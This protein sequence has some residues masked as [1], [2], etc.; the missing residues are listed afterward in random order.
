MFDNALQIN[1]NLTS[2]YSNKGISFNK[3]FKGVCLSYVGK[4]WDAFNM[5]DKALEIN[6]YLFEVYTN[7]GI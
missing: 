4:F 7:K 1:P 2:A 5:I 3:F 6:P